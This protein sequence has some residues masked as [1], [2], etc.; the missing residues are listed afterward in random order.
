MK[1]IIIRLPNKKAVK[2]SAHLKSE[3][4][5]YSKSL[6]ILQGGKR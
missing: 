6:K 2:F 3:H 4:P 5:K 1:R